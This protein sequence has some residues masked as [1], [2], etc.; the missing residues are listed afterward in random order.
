MKVYASC[1]PSLPS[2]HAILSPYR[3]AKSFVEKTAIPAV[4]KTIS[5]AA[6]VK[7][8]ANSF[9]RVLKFAGYSLGA[10]EIITGR[11]YLG[12]LSNMMG[13]ADNLID[14]VQVFGDLDYWVSGQVFED[15]GTKIYNA[16]YKVA[17][18][19]SFFAA[20]ALGILMWL[21]ELK[22][23]NLAKIAGNIESKFPAFK[24]V[25]QAG[26]G[27]ICRSIVGA[28]FVFYAYDA[29]KR[30]DLA[31]HNIDHLNKK[32]A[33][34]EKAIARVQRKID[35]GIDAVEEKKAAENRKS[36]QRASCPCIG[37]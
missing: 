33:K 6:S 32:I 4:Q 26:L 17:A 15:W 8:D 3:H 24:V 11:A 12:I 20:D 21:D 5:V 10:V 13:N 25:G 28:A 7:E 29:H 34:E 1:C 18:F 27:T 22:F 35:Q 14:T 36:N 9:A 19:V 37:L 16:K 31:N 23:I 2:S 30:I